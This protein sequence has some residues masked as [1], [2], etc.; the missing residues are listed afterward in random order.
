MLFLKPTPILLYPQSGLMMKISIALATYNG[1]K[2]LSEQLNSFVNQTRMPDELIVS[3]DLSTDST[4]EIIKKFA[5]KA[6]FNVY[7]SQ[8]KRNLGYA[9][10]F[11]EALSST[12]GDL[13]LLSDQ[14]DV[15][16]SN[17]I[18]TIENVATVCE[19]LLIIN[20]KMITD[21]NLKS[22]GVSTFKIISSRPKKLQKFI[23]GSFTSIK[24]EL[25]D[26]CL[27]IPQEFSSH[28]VWIDHFA[29]ALDSKKIVNQCLQFYRRHE[30]AT[31]IKKKN[32]YDEE[33]KRKYYENKYKQRLIEYDLLVE[34]MS[35]AVGHI[36]ST[37]KSKLIRYRDSLV[38]M[39]EFSVE[40]EK[41]RKKRRVS[42]IIPVAGFLINGDY[43]NINGL[44]SAV[45][46]I[47]F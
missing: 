14:D 40:R 47:L 26:L 19:E 30:T 17:K 13:V 33:E 15:W 4:F 9:V 24:R 22:T 39:R 46:D 10:N 42:R 5:D 12:T 41:I 32:R 23:S 27:P 31:M 38:R 37:K 36:K 8:N 3:D 20:D 28:D 1:A 35:E 34:A 44:R 29:T 2:H 7:Y 21:E 18:E 43:A 25:L 6:P 11:N 45:H 16:F